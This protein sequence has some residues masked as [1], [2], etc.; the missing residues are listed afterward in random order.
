MVWIADQRITE[1]EPEM[2]EGY[3][4]AI[5]RL[6][7]LRSSLG[8]DYAKMGH[9]IA[10]H[11]TIHVVGEFHDRVDEHLEYLRQHHRDW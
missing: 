8:T 2:R 5:S 1:V 9:G 7:A 6:T 10:D 11:E 4:E 3:R